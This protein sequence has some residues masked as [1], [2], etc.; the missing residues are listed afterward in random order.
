MGIP[1]ENMPNFVSHVILILLST[2]TW[3]LCASIFDASF[4]THIEAWIVVELIVAALETLYGIWAS[5]IDSRDTT[6]Y[7]RKSESFFLVD[8]GLLV[9]NVAMAVT[10]AVYWRS[11][12]QDRHLIFDSVVVLVWLT[13]L[14]LMLIT[15]QD[16]LK[17]NSS[18]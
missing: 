18:S 15:A 10:G 13:L 3:V 11:G 9:V 4:P 17:M 14:V 1:S 16:R 2:A 8:V 5:V 12:D 6:F 7:E